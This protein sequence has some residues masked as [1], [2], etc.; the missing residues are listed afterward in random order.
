[1]TASFKG[2]KGVTYGFTDED[3][4]QVTRHADDEGAVTA[5]N[6]FEAE[7]FRS[8]GLKENEAPAEKPKAKSRSQKPKAAEPKAVPKPKA[9]S[10]QPALKET[11]GV[12]AGPHGTAA[13]P[14]NS[15]P[16]V[17]TS[18]APAATPTNTSGSPATPAG[19]EG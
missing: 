15:S 8:I 4:S 17:N 1:M 3:G 6:G 16:A 5:R 12:P 2:Q 9:A 13:A 10:A 7:H 19:A 14:A 11:T 18:A